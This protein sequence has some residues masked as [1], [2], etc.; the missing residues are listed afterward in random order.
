M[1]EF[2]EE[3]LFTGAAQSQGFAPDQAPDITPFLRENM[4]QEDRNFAQLKSQQQA[5]NEAQL[6][7]AIQTYKG[8]AA[9]SPKFMELAKFAGD[10]YI[11]NQMVEGNAKTR[12]LGLAGVDP[13]KQ[14]EYDATIQNLKQENAEAT[15]VA[16]EAHKNGAPPE[17]VSFIKNLPQ[18]QE[19][20]GRLNYINNR[21]NGYEPSLTRFLTNDSIQLQGVDGVFTPSQINGDPVKLG[22]ALDAHAKMYDVRTGVEYFS[23]SALTKYNDNILKVHQEFTTKVRETQLKT[24]GDSRVAT[25]VQSFTR[26]L[27]INSLV[28]SIAGTY[29][30]EGIRSYADALDMVY[31]DIIP[32]LRNADRISTQ[33]FREAI[34]Q[35]AAND[36]KNRPHSIFYEKRIF[37]KGGT[38]DKVNGFDEA[39]IKRKERERDR[40][41]EDDKQD[42][43][44]QTFEADEQGIAFTNDQLDARLRSVMQRTGIYDPSKFKYYQDYK[45]KEELD[46]DVIRDELNYLGSVNGRGYLVAEDL[47]G[48]PAAIVSEFTS[49]VKQDEEFSKFAEAYNDSAKRRTTALVNEL[50]KQEAGNDEK[51]VEWNKSYDAMYSA[52]LNARDAEFQQTLDH[53]AAHAAGLKAI[54]D[55][56]DSFLKP[57]PYS[58]D[59]SQRRTLIENLRTKMRDK[60]SIGPADFPENIKNNL[61]QFDKGLVDTYDPIFDLMALGSPSIT[62]WNIANNLFR[63]LEGRS[64]KKTVKQEAIES[65]GPAVQRFIRGTGPTPNKAVRAMK[66]DDPNGSFNPQPRTYEQ[67]RSQLVAPP[68]REAATSQTKGIDV[69]FKDGKFPAYYDGIV[70]NTGTD[71]RQGGKVGYGYYVVIEHTDPA[72]GMKFDGIYSHL[73]S[74]SPLKPGQ[75]VAA[76]QMIGMQGATGRTVPAGTPVSSFDALKAQ[77]PYS[78]DMT[79]YENADA[80]IDALIKQLGGSN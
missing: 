6:K 9:F 7:K 63:K 74:E 59:L 27:D 65:N 75:R 13:F 70:K 43:F 54:Q 41:V 60:V 66:M 55:D 61:R 80:L 23:K 31:K 64:L 4:E 72:T 67:I 58:G 14:A 79:P 1:A 15:K 8:L 37:E 18:Y 76:G 78:L 11:S 44:K 57:A 20:E 32:S 3:N 51:S 48:K 17:A 40:L 49:R 22:I 36:P 33:Q 71:F 25:A 34:E 24:N 5:Q 39:E 28:A 21:Q 50:Y 10:A 19:I 12:S 69:Q 52:Y 35:P 46:V 53:K 29:G 56:R 47:R 42:F 38:W 77:P 26:D 16:L 62:G 2:Q 30:P 68:I 45:T 73:A